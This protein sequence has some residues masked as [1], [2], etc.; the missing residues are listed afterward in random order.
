MKKIKFIQTN[1][2]IAEISAP[3]PSYMFLP[4]WYKSFPRRVDKNSGPVLPGEKGLNSSIKACV[5]VLDA[6]SGG[7]IVSLPC[8]VQIGS[9]E[10]D[11]F[12]AAWQ[13][14]YDVVGE[15]NPDQI[16]LEMIPGGFE[17]ITLKW[18][19]NWI[20]ETYPGYSCLFTHPL[21]RFDLPFITMSGIVDTD[22]H[23]LE[24]NFPFFIKEN[25]YGIIPEGTPVAQIFPFKRDNWKSNI[26]DISQIERVRLYNKTRTKMENFYR[27]RSWSRKRYV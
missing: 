12:K 23:N 4:E 17:R 24:I 16:P 3:K 14:S 6:M 20:I 10:K 26:G 9:L 7:Y 11:G 22:K 25:F 15:H 5:P 19:N 8:D 1:K 21:N 13:V 2:E 18:I 27:D